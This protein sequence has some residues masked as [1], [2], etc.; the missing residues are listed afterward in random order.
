MLYISLLL[1]FRTVVVML[2]AI[3]KVSFK[4]LYLNIKMTSNSQGDSGVE[5]ICIV[6]ML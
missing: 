1:N 6:S 3:R 4:Y 2:C 5:G